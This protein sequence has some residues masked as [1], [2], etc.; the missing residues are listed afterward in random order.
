MGRSETGRALSGREL[1]GA[2]GMVAAAMIASRVLGLFRNTIVGAT[3]G[4][5]PELDAFT[6]AQRLPETLFVLVAGGALGSA[7]IPVFAGFLSRGEREHAWKLASGVANLLV[8]VSLAVSAVA[9]VLA[10]QISRHLLMPGATVSQQ[11]LTASLMRIM[12]ATVAVFGISGLVMGVLNAHQHF[13]LPALAPSMYNLGIIAGALFLTR[14]YGVYGLAWGTVLGTAL[15]L[16]VQVPG[17]ARVAARY[18]L[19]GWGAPGVGEVLSLMGPR[20]LG[21]A[22]VQVNFWVNNALASGMAEGSIGVLTWGFQLMLMPQAVIA[23]STA[24]AV[25]PSLSVMFAKDDMDGFRR[26]LSGALRSV[27]YLAIPA[28][29]GL[30]VLAE[31]IVRLLYEYG[32]WSAESTLATAWAL[33]FWAIGLVAHCAVEVLVRAFYALHDTRTPVL[34]GGGAMLLNVLFSLLFIRFVGVPGEL[35][36]G[37]FAGL[38]LANSTA[39]ALE[40]IG[41]WVLLGRRLGGMDGRAVWDTVWKAGVASLL[42]G[43]LI[44]GVRIAL[45]GR[46]AFLTVGIA[47]LGGL[48]LFAGVTIALGSREAGS[49]VAMALR[50]FGRKV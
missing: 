48:V 47:G 31:P 20:V 38:A 33:Q 28:T 17:L 2:T 18:Y 10:P 35:A 40:M 42:M 45:A 5:G 8:V 46:A 22:I 27:L 7:F 34:I 15:H 32:N 23:Q 26:V 49:V 13:L 41:L 6:A 37:P 24:T 19:I 44:Y 21:L 3:F 25:F 39:T 50:A 14:W 9:F 12:L 11:M 16:A 43:A 1:A 4:A 36:H 30:V 29:V